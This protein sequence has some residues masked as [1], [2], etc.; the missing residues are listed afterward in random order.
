MLD[1][2][3]EDALEQHVERGIA[4]ACGFRIDQRICDFR[5]RR[6]CPGGG[7]AGKERQA[8]RGGAPVV[9]K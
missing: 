5:H 4:E 8:E 3:V 1:L 6:A 7:A 9:R 2:V